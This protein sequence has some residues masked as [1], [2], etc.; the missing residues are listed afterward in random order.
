MSI[1]MRKFNSQKM[2][3]LVRG[4]VLVL[5]G[6]AFAASLFRFYN[7]NYGIYNNIDKSCSWADSFSDKEYALTAKNNCVKEKLTFRS[8]NEEEAWNFFAF[9]IL[10]P[11]IFFAVNKAYNYTFTKK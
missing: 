10:V 1:N 3:K 11:L 7:I 4:I 5:A 8:Q 2:Y 9:S 6:L